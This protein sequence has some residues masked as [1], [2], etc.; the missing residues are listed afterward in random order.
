MTIE[1]AI[2]R[3]LKFHDVKPKGDTIKLNC[4][5]V[6]FDD[7]NGRKYWIAVERMVTKHGEKPLSLS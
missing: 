6:W 1:E 5:C 7:V 3:L 4:G 2:Q